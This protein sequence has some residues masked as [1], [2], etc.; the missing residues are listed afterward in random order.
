MRIKE[1]IITASAVALSLVAM[2]GIVHS[3]QFQ[4]AAAIE[5]SGF[6]ALAH[7]VFAHDAGAS[8]ALPLKAPGARGE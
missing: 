1:T 6:D 5:T 3:T 8:A 4:Q 2:T 7:S